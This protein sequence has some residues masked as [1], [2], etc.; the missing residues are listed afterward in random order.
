[1]VERNLGLTERVT[2]SLGNTLY[3]IS[4]I[5]VLLS[6]RRGDPAC[7]TTAELRRESNLGR[8]S[9]SP[10]TLVLTRK[11]VCNLKSKLQ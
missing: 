2:V 8:E 9:Q 4:H 11:A 5:G 3:A 6:T 7:R 10:I 1:L